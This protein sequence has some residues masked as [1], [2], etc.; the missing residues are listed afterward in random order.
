[1]AARKSG[2]GRGLDALLQVDRP[3]GGFALIAVDAIDPNPR[4]PR[5]RFQQEALAS[6]ADSIREV[7]VLQPLGFAS[8]RR[9][10]ASP[11]TT[12]DRGSER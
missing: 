6:L 9:R 11:H 12:S 10:A 1:M 7:G 5:G 4:Q 2:L 8:D 3:T